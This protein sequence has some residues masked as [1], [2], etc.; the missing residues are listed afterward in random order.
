MAVVNET[1]ESLKN[2]LDNRL[3]IDK[4]IISPTEKFVALQPNADLDKI[5]TIWATDLSLEQLGPKF[6][7]VLHYENIDQLRRKSLEAMVILFLGNEHTHTIGTVMSRILVAK[8]HSADVER[9]IS[10]NNLL[11]MSL[12]S[13][14][15]FETENL[16]IFVN[17]N[18][19]PL[20]EWDLRDTVLSWLTEKNCRERESQRKPDSRHGIK[21][22]LS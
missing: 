14:M 3:N 12:R 9:L 7:D 8:P 11:K 18:M 15:T 4:G 6:D 21:E 19:P 1:I 20:E 10:K 17:E 2:F 13:S 22:Y 5:Y 16:Y